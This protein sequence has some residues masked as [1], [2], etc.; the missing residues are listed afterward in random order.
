MIRSHLHMGVATDQKEN[1][2]ERFVVPSSN[3]CFTHARTEEVSKW[4][5]TGPKTNGKNTD[6]DRHMEFLSERGFKC[7][8]QKDCGH[9][10]NVQETGIF[11]DKGKPCVLFPSFSPLRRNIACVVSADIRRGFRSLKRHRLQRFLTKRWHNGCES[12]T[13]A[14]QLPRFFLW[15]Y[16]R[17]EQIWFLIST[18]PFSKCS[19]VLALQRLWIDKPVSVNPE[20]CWRKWQPN[21][22][23]HCAK[24][25]PKSLPSCAVKGNQRRLICRLAVLHLSEKGTACV[26]FHGRKCCNLPAEKRNAKVLDLSMLWV[27]RNNSARTNRSTQ[28]NSR[29]V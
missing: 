23:L 22:V 18:S 20:T 14:L 19:R 8:G 17:E 16:E 25:H 2:S 29:N 6:G 28:W 11:L 1:E 13:K 27:R 3:S 24:E 21:L 26:D 9:Q 15:D 5:K 7:T 10:D 4:P 12:G